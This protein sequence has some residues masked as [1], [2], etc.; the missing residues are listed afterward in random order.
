MDEMRRELQEGSLAGDAGREE[1]LLE[2]SR[3]GT[4]REGGTAEGTAGIREG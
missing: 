1:V 2:E 3:A 4:G